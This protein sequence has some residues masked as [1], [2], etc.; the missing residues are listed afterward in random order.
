MWRRGGAAGAIGKDRAVDEGDERKPD[1][2]ARGD[3]VERR[4]G[5]SAKLIGLGVVALLLLVFVIQ[6]TDKADVDLLLWDAV[7]PIWLVI[8]IAAALGLAAGWILGRVG[9]PRRRD[10]G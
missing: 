5:P 10:A 4:E 7:L 2:G 6:N 1:H 9:R 8:V 3:W